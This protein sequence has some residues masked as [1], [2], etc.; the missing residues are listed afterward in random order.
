MELYRGKADNTNEES[1]GVTTEGKIL[2]AICIYLCIVFFI[3]S[4]K[5]DVD[6]NSQNIKQVEKRWVHNV[7]GTWSYSI[8]GENV[9]EKLCEIDGKMYYF[10]WRGIMQTDTFKDSYYLG[11]DGASVTNKWIKAWADWKY[12][13]EDG[14]YYIDKFLF[15]NN[16]WY[17]FDTSGKMAENKW[18]EYKGKKYHFNGNGVMQKNQYIKLGKDGIGYLT[19]DGS[20]LTSGK[21]DKY[22]ADIDGYLTIAP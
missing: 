13:G 4:Y 18:I 17:Y 7:D 15:Y 5:G 12:Y 2:I 1:K 11:K 22:I 19:E 3:R 8:D 21:I 10:D 20:L 16:E 14:K 9:F 6:S